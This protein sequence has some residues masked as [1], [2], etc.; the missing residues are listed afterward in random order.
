MI[1]NVYSFYDEAAQAYT[2]PFFMHND[3][4]AIRAFSDNIN[5]KDDNNMTNHPEHFTLFRIATFDDKQGIITKEE[6]IAA[7]GNGIQFKDAAPDQGDITLIHE[8]IDELAKWFGE[9]RKYIHTKSTLEAPTV[10]E[11]RKM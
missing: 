8:R 6:P 2:T 7:L 9:Y 10:A 4:M 11:M 1:I 3:G 5:S